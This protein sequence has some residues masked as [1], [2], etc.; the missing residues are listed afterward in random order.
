MSTKLGK[1]S[2]LLTQTSEECVGIL[3]VKMEEEKQTCDLDSILHWSNSYSPETFCQQFRQFGYQ[4]SLGLR[5]A[6]RQLWE[7]CHLWLRL[8]VH[9]K[10]QILELLVLE[11]FL[12]ILPKEL[13]AWVQNRH[14]ENGEEAVT[15]LEGVERELDGPE[16]IRR[17][18][19]EMNHQAESRAWAHHWELSSQTLH[20]ASWEPQS[21]RP[22]GEGA[23]FSSWWK[24]WGPSAH[25]THLC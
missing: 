11:Q 20:G 21:L 2:S 7:L 13:Q 19:V 6:L 1:S 5:E 9:T 3:T 16:Q 22:H 12:A 15:M 10:E 24:M 23:E 25:H 14:P 17:M 4:D 18:P 8:E